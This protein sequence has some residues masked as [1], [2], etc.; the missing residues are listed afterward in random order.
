VLLTVL[1][2][3]VIIYS[4]SSY[5]HTDGVDIFIKPKVMKVAKIVRKVLF[6][7]MKN[8]RGSLWTSKWLSDRC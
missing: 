4:G 8:E 3:L 5:P 7:F 2:N 1:P 6:C